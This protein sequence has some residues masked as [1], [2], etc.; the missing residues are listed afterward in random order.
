MDKSQSMIDF[1]Q[2]CPVIKLN[3]LFFN[4][5]SKEDNAHQAIVKADDVNLQKPYI[6]GSVEKRYTFSVDSFKTVA[7]N[8]VIQGLTDENLDDFKDVQELLDWVTSQDDN[9]NYPDFGDKCFIDNMKVLTEK[10][11]ILGIDTSAN[12]PLAVYR[13]SIQIDYIDSSKVL[14]NESTSST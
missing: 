5:G 6:D 7:Y 3:P 13:I 4:F 11:E 12:P 8:P 14:W 10:P 9:R 1:L 2:S